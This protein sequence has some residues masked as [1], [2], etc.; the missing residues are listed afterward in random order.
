MNHTKKEGDMLFQLFQAFAF[1]FRLSVT[2]SDEGQ[3][4]RDVHHGQRVRVFRR[5]FARCDQGSENPGMVI[6]HPFHISFG[7]QCRQLRR[8]ELLDGHHAAEPA[9]RFIM[10]RILEDLPHLFKECIGG[11]FREDGNILCRV[12]HM[13]VDLIGIRFILRRRSPQGFRLPR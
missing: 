1:P 4:R 3:D 9:D 8:T 7:I 5:E 10:E 2:D 6:Q 13:D 12:L 11:D